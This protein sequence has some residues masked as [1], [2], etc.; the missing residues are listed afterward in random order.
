MPKRDVQATEAANFFS[1]KSYVDKQGGEVLFGLDWKERKGQLWARCGGRCEQITSDGMRCRSEAH[2]PDHII[3][4]SKGR[5]DALSNLQALCRLHHD[6]K[7]P[8]KQPQ[9]SKR[10]AVA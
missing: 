7:H 2:D 5:N 3:P 1:P 10:E 9:W 4:R 6:L 8:E